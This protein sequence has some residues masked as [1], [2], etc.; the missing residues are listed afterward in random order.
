MAVLLTRRAVVRAAV[1]TVYNTPVVMGANDGVL[2]A[3]PQFTADPNVLERNFTRDTLSKQ[4]HIIG[5]MMAKMEFE[6]ELRGNSKQQLGTLLSAPILSRLLRACGYAITANAT[7]KGGAVFEVNTHLNEV[8]WT[9][10]SSTLTNTDVINYRLKV[11]TGGASGAATVQVLS[12]TV[13]EANAAVAITSGSVFS[14]GSKGLKLTP[15]FTGNLVAG[16]EWVIWV[17]P[18]GLSLDPISN[19]FE[20]I[21][22]EMFKDGVKHT[23]PG[24]FGTFVI[25]AAAGTFATIKWTFMGTWQQPVD[26]AMPT[27]IYERTLPSMVELA[28]LRMDGFYAVVET[29][30]FDQKNDVQIRPDVSSEQGY[31][32]TRIVSRSPE[33]GINPEADLVANYDFWGQMRAAARMPFQM[34]VGK[35]IGNTV[36]ITAPS[37]QYSGMT[38]SDRQGILAYDAGLKFA[39]YRNDDE[40]KFYFC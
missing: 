10:D 18:I 21:T 31:I 26:Q 5:R 14:V 36:W 15:T 37:T 30:T 39:G 12:E 20:S 28:R 40:V 2:V 8:A 11:I 27:P 32:G 29:F 7:P 24:S 22:L 19:G 9:V 34:R 33:G 1:E 4:S 13:G 38:Y 25:T 16:A 23:M 35:D 17:Y 3:S 6:T